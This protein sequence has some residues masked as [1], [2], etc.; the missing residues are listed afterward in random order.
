MAESNIVFKRGS[1]SK[2]KDK[3]FLEVGEENVSMQNRREN[4]LIIS[5][6]AP[7]KEATNIYQFFDDFDE[8]EPIFVDIA[9]AGDVEYYFRGISPVNEMGEGDQS[10]QQFSV[11]LQLRREFI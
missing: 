3:E 9:S 10:H 5:F 7:E 6:K 11:T 2:M 4:A 1:G 8:L